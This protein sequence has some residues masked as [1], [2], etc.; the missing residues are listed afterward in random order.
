MCRTRVL[1]G[2]KEAKKTCGEK[3]K[4]IICRSSSE[5]KIFSRISTTHHMD[6]INCSM[7]HQPLRFGIDLQNIIL[8]THH[9]DWITI[10]WEWRPFACNC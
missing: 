9:C 1:Y 10:C 2:S 3:K 5:N 4:V 6:A 7:V 8:K